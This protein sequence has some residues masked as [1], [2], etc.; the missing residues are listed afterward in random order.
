MRRRRSHLVVVLRS[1]CVLFILLSAVLLSQRAGIVPPLGVGWGDGSAARAYSVGV[2]GSIVFETLAGVKNMPGGSV[3]GVDGRPTD[4]L[5][6]H[7][8]RWSLVAERE[9]RT[10]L[11]GIYG[12]KIEVGISAWWAVLL[13]L[14]LGWRWRAQVQSERRQM[15][16][17]GPHCRKCGYDLRATPDRCPECGT[18]ASAAGDK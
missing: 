17:V 1:A 14:A 13:S 16:A 5:G 12:T 10:R 11:P 8:Y 7:Y 9:D 6:L 18:I 2:D 4:L 3:I 15:A